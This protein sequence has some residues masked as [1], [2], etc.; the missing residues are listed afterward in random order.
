MELEVTVRQR[1]NLRG[2]YRRLERKK[3]RRLFKRRDRGLSESSTHKQAIDAAALTIEEREA[4]DQAGR[5]D[6][7]FRKFVEDHFD[8]DAYLVRYPDVKQAGAD[9]VEHWL[10]WG[11]FEGRDMSPKISVAVGAAKKV[12][13]RGWQHFTWQGSPVAVLIRQDRQRI[14]DQ[15]HEQSQFDLSILSAGALAIDSLKELDADDLI[16]RDQIDVS[17]IFSSLTTRP[18]TVIAIPF[19]RTGGPEK[20]AANLVGTLLDEGEAPILIVVTEDTKESSAGWESLDILSPLGEH[21]VMFWRDACGPAH[22]N[23]TVFARFLNALR[24][25]TIVISN[26]RV[27]LEAVANFGRGLSQHARV[28]CTYFCAGVDGLS[29]PYGAWFPPRT[30]PFAAA[31]TDNGQMAETLRR[32]WAGGL[33][34]PGIVELPPKVALASESVYRSR[35]AARLERSTH[36]QHRRRWAWVS[37]LDPFKG[38]AILSELAVLRPHDYFEMYGPV[39]GK[40]GDVGLTAPNIL[41]RGVLDSVAAADFQNY[42]GFVFTSLFEGMPN[43]ALEMSQHAI[44]L[45]LADVGGLRETFNDQGALFVEHCDTLAAT[46][47]GFSAALDRLVAMSEAEIESLLSAARDQV[48]N[49]HAPAA[50]TA[51]FKKIFGRRK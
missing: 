21:E 13:A 3:M 51:Q 43:I 15:I 24:P 9:P 14:L 28:F 46:A 41:H 38:T 49:R 35:L 36:Q 16:A 10:R 44:P 25:S 33:G 30:L 17:T 12:D 11:I 42:D 4:D 32:M 23:P 26:S 45:I 34:G 18:R 7:A 47:A 1:S 39:Q 40:L 27:G 6:T 31:L 22:N 20:Y 8:R 5:G 2:F 50:Y 19:L 37:R 29:A 48:T